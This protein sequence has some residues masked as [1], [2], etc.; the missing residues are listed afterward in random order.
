M[1][2]TSEGGR[3]EE[4]STCMPLKVSLAR[5]EESDGPFVLGESWFSP[6]WPLCGRQIRTDGI[7]FLSVIKMRLK[8]IGQA[9][10]R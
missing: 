6:G 2:K 1:R 10:Q 3:R 7:V 8:K 4:K 9:D 5:L